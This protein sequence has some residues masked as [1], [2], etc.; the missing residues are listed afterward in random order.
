MRAASNDIITLGCLPPPQP[1]IDERLAR[2]RNA[3]QVTT[4]ALVAESPNY[5]LN[6][7]FPIHLAVWRWPEP[8]QH[9]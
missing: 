9:C 5:D 4:E 7:A 8:I 6:S 1:I 2:T 3:T